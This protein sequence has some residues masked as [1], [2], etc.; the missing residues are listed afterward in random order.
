MILKKLQ[1]ENLRSYEKQE[2]DFPKGSTLLS[3]DIGSG[4][5][6]ILLAVE[7][8][9]FVLQPSQKGRKLLRTGKEKAKVI[10]EFEIEGKNIIIERTLKRGKKSV[11]QGYATIIIDNEKF[12]GSITEIK[13]RILKLLNY[14]AE[15]TKKTNLLYKFTVYTPQEEMKQIILEPG[16]IRLNT[17]RHVFG[18]DKYKRIQENTVILTSKLRE[19]IRINEGIIYDLE[20]YKE[21]LKQK[22][23]DL[24]NLEKKR[25]QTIKEHEKA[26]EFSI[27]KEKSLEEIKEKINEKK[28]LE[29]QK[30]TSDLLI[31]EKT[32]QI[33]TLDNN[34]KTLKLQIEEAKKIS[35]SKEDFDSL[36]KRIEFQ[37]NKQEDL[38]K[39]Y[40]QIISKIN[41]G[42]SKKTEAED[43]KNKISKIQKCPTC[44]QNVSEEYKR[45]IFAKADEE[46]Q[47]SQ[48]NL[49]NF[50]LKKKQLTEQINLSKKALE[51]F[52]EKKSELELL[53]IKSENLIEKEQRILDTE[54]QKQTISNDLE[55]LKKHSETIEK[56]ILEYTKYD[57]IF[58]KRNKELNDAKQNE[59]NI[60]IKKAEINKEV[61]FAEKQIKE[62]QEQIKEKEEL[63]ERT[64]KIKEIEYW[65]SEKF[66]NLILF[67]ERQVMLTLK[68]EFSQLFSKWFAILVS[69]SLS[70]KLNEEFSPVIEQQDYELDYSFLS[71]G[72]RTAIALAYRLSL[73]QVINSLLSNIK[74]RNLVILDEPTDGFSAQQLDKMRDVLSQLNTEQLILVS[75]EP[76]IESFVDNIIRFTKEGGITKVEK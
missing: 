49:D 54:K 56:S 30:K 1:I 73:N 17:L 53:K 39:E 6:T 28:T 44:L 10:L 58:K 7:F 41:T 16:D 34:L 60:A 31:S 63:K 59:N 42:E 52:K 13:N 62:K 43:L 76:K 67:T 11:S 14:P 19:K 45:N 20:K 21:E 55:M 51:N 72:E 74:T 8:A 75:H 48:R 32:Q 24:I 70:A 23:Q 40:I 12:E 36:N 22:K 71:G 57:E 2:I 68:Q 25:K 65:I 50:S 27:T 4:K 18:I 38:Q 37:Q 9:L 33:T 15:F 66:L 46:I 69:D 47:A 26:I 64:E 61:Q 5:T 35:F 29:N 3:G